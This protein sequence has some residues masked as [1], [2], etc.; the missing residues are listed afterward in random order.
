MRFQQPSQL[1]LSYQVQGAQLLSERERGSFA[2][3]DVAALLSAHEAANAELDNAIL[4][5]MRQHLNEEALVIFDDFSGLL[6][7]GLDPL[8]ALRLFRKILKTVRQVRSKRQ[9]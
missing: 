3:I 7:S 6:H 4:T 5:Q 8:I 2:Y 1:M 9:A